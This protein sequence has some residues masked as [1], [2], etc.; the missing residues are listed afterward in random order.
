MSDT[1]EKTNLLGLSPAKMEAFFLSIGEKKFRAQQMLKW[2]HQYGESDFEKMTNMGKALRAKLADVSEIV[3][4]EVVYED[5]SKDG[6]RKWVM[7]MPGGSAVETVYIPEKDR[8]T[9]CVSSQ[10]GCALDCSFCS[11]GKQ[12]FNRDLT[13]AEIIGQLYVAAM[14]FHQPGERRERRI[15]NVVMMGMGEP[16][17]NFDNVVDAM[18]LMMDDNAYGLSKRRVTLS[19]SGVVPMIDK[20]GDVTDVSLAISLHAPNDELRNTLVPL[21]KKYPLSELIAAT[22]R[23]L[24][25]LPD[26]RK[27]TIEYTL[28]D[29]VNDEM[30]HAEELAELMKLVPCKINLIPFN[31]FPNSGYRR[32]SNNRVYR[33]RDYLV[34]QGHVVTIRSTRG[35]DID[36]ACGQLVGKVED[37]TRRSQRYIDAVQI[38]AEQ[39]GRAS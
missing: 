19:T 4:P 6:T 2:I 14:S 8:G 27:A 34:S 21:N 12:G 23:Y 31:P 7:R 3:L 39:G 26:K 36:A 5:F 24:G 22:N 29:G 18:N 38:D 10:I 20:L 15:T 32:P 37:R 30:V 1:S 35:D 13:V 11:T 16:L 28:M 17:L 9:L 33:F 25:K